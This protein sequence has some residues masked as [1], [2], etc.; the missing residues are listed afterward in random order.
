MRGNKGTGTEQKGTIVPGQN[1][2][3]REQNGTHTLRVCSL[4]PLR[5]GDFRGA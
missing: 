4:V 3:K 2:G 1:S 5:C